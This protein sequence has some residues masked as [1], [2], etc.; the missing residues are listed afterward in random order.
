MKAIPTVQKYMTTLPHTVGKE[1]TLEA[2]K[3]MMKQHGIRHLPVLGGGELVGILSERDIDY[4]LTFK[5]VDARSEKVEQAMTLEMFKVGINTPLDELCQI[6]AEKKIGSA[7]IEDNRKLV[8]IFTWV[9]ALKAT[10]ELL[11]T[12]LKS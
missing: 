10:S 4:I 5:D 3:K 11:H 6:M 2:A 12:R 8:G 1:Q 9:D 7:L